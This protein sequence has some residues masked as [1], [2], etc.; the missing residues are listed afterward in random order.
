MNQFQLLSADEIVRL[1]HSLGKVDSNAVQALE[2]HLQA[3]WIVTIDEAE[4]LFQIDRQVGR[5]DDNCPAWRSLFI[6]A[7]S[8]FVVFDMNTPGEISAEEA[9]W[10]RRH[11]SPGSDLTPNEVQLLKHMRKHST[12]C[13]ESM[14]NLFNLAQA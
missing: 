8:R 14:Q 10:L 13:C 2:K 1:V 12:S 7:I 5:Q 9:E 3:D 4:L 6:E 11:L